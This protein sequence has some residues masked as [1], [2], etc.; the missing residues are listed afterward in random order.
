MPP[1][2]GRNLGRADGA[3]HIGYCVGA[4]GLDAARLAYVK[5][6]RD[7]MLVLIGLAGSYIP[8]PSVITQPNTLLQPAIGPMRSSLMPF[9]AE[10][11]TPLSDR[12]GSM[13]WG[14]PLGV[15][16]LHRQEHEVERLDYVAHLAEVD[17]VRLDGEVALLSRDG[18]A[19]LPY[20]F[21]VC[22][23]LIYEG[24]VVSRPS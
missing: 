23:P 9:W 16:G 13:K 3:Q 8:A 10:T 7:A 4:P 17:G 21:D 15:V 6:R 11:I 20:R 2:I 24:H 14:R 5:A 19:L 18:Q 1:Q 12:W 22:R